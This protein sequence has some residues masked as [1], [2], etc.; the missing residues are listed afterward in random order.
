MQYKLTTEW[1]WKSFRIAST[2]PH[3]HLVFDWTMA[4][5]TEWTKEQSTLKWKLMTLIM[6]TIDASRKHRLKG[7]L[8]AYVRCN[9]SRKADDEYKRYTTRYTCR[10]KW[11]RQKNSFYKSI[12]R[13]RTDNMPSG[14]EMKIADDAMRF[15]SSEACACAHS[16]P[17]ETESLVYK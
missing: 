13:A 9:M 17:I 1:N 2:S 12:L 6:M 11:N 3:F 14:W 5:A 15:S 4:W 16:P 8:T 7:V 10:T